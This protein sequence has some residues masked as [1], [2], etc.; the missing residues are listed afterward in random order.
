MLDVYLFSKY[1]GH[2]DVCY[3]RNIH[4]FHESGLGCMLCSEIH[5]FYIINHEFRIQ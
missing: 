2:S 4:I 5:L 3:E 1:K